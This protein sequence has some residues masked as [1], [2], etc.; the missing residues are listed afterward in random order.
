MLDR[1]ASVYRLHVVRASLSMGLHHH[2]ADRPDA[3]GGEIRSATGDVIVLAIKLL[4]VIG[5][6]RK[7]L[8]GLCFWHIKGRFAANV[9]ENIGPLAD[10]RRGG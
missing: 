6:D 1:S 10:D 4:Q 5:R 7:W 2:G 9:T 3:A 8:D